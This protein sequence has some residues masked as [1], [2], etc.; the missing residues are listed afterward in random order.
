MVSLGSSDV[1]KPRSAIS[2]LEKQAERNIIDSR[3]EN[4]TKFRYLPAKI[5]GSGDQ[6]DR[7]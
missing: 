2:T 1:F 7:K 6:G 4:T 3:T 5:S